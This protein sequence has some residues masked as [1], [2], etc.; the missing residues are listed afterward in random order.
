MCKLYDKMLSMA[1]VAVRSQMGCAVFP[2]SI[3]FLKTFHNECVLVPY[4]GET[5]AFLKTLQ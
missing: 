5:M 3:Q 1:T 2:V 4:E